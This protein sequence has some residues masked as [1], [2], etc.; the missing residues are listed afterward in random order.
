VAEGLTAE[1]RA[2]IA[3]ALPRGKVMSSEAWAELEECVVGYRIFETRRLTYPIV[4]HRKYREHMDKAVATVILGLCRDDMWPGD[5]TWWRPDAL[6]AM[7]AIRRRVEA[8]AAFQ[9]MWGKPFSRRQNPDREFLY[10]AVMR[11]WTDHLGGELRYSKSRK[12]S[13]PL[14]RFFVAR[15]EPILGDKTPGAGIGDIIDREKKSR[16]KGE[17]NKR[18]QREHRGF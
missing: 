15:V 9:D 2:R 8:L 5:T 14:I 6:A 7:S 1:H 18:W 17:A 10:W 13:G 11:V 3:A 4:K 16:A 12:P